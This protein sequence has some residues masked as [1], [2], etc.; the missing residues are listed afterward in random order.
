MKGGQGLGAVGGE[1]DEGWGWKGKRKEGGRNGRNGGGWQKE[2]RSWEP[3]IE[4]WEDGQRRRGKGD[5]SGSEP[6]DGR[7]DAARG[8]AEHWGPGCVGSGLRER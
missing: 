4:K 2:T 5:S 6:R 8:C 1:W 7:R 3:N